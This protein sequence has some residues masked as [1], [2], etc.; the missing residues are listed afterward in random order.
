MTALPRKITGQVLAPMAR[1]EGRPR[2][3]SA[4]LERCEQHGEYPAML[5]AGSWSTCVECA[6]GDEM[7]AAAAAQVAW[8]GQLAARAWDARLG[9]AATSV[10]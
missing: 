8:R 5:V 7:A 10:Q 3:F 9:R 6:K 4:T 1:S 2:Y